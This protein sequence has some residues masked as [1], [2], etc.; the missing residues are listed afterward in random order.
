MREWVDK[1]G[2][3]VEGDYGREEGL[4]LL[5][6]VLLVDLTVVGAHARLPR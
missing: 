5:E 6:V 3:V 4:V 1:V 2:V